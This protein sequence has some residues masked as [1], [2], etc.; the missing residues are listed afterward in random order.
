[1]RLPERTSRVT[2]FV[3]VGMGGVGSE[4]SDATAALPKEAND[5]TTLAIEEGRDCDGKP[6]GRVS[7]LATGVGVGVD[8]RRCF[9]TLLALS[10]SWLVLFGL[11]RAEVA[12]DLELT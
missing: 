8:G 5:N 6:S 12:C 1:M 10:I 3:D 11:L 4:L 9:A 7:A 2:F